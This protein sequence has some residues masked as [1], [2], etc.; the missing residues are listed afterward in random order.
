VK[1][2]LAVERRRVDLAFYSLY[3]DGKEPPDLAAY[4]RHLA[5]LYEAPVLFY[6]VV[7]MA[8]ASGNGQGLMLV[9]AW[10]YV[11]ARYLHSLIHLTGNVVLWRFQAFSVSWLVLI[12][13]WAVLAA[14]LLGLS[15]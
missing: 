10:C 5:N 14:R 12:A 2:Y 3:Q 7:I 1:R 11:G 9:L 6:A 15:V 13:L 4:T 8:Y